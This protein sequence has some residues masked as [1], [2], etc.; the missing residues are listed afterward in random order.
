[1]KLWDWLFIAI[2]ADELAAIE[3]YERI[4]DKGKLCKDDSATTISEGS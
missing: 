3:E 4:P 2:W 1:M